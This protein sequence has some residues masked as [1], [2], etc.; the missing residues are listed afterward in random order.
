M[1]VY[2]QFKPRLRG[3]RAALPRLAWRRRLKHS[4]A[5]A[6][7]PEGRAPSAQAR[8]KPPRLRTA[9]HANHNLFGPWQA[10]YRGMRRRSAG[11]YRHV[12]Q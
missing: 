2:V 4:A 10:V 1:P 3:A 11:R 8:P 12:E 5:A 7:L 6:V 9:V